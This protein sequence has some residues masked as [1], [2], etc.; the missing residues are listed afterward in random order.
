MYK[1]LVVYLYSYR[2][3]E[4][5]ESCGYVKMNIHDGECKM[6]IHIKNTIGIKGSMDIYLLKKED[7]KLIGKKIMDGEE[8]KGNMDVRYTCKCSDMGGNLSIDEVLGILIYNGKNIQK[9]ICG[10]MKSE[11]I[12]IADYD[13]PDAMSVLQTEEIREVEDENSVYEYDEECLKQKEQKKGSHENMNGCGKYMQ[14]QE[15]KNMEDWQEKIFHVFPKVVINVNGEETSGIKLKPHD[16]VWFPGKYWRLASNKFLLNGYY[17][18]RY[19]LFFKGTGENKG[20]YYLGTPGNFGVNS[21]ITA[22]QFGF[23]DFFPADDCNENENTFLEKN[24]RNFGFW[25][26]EA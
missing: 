10:A 13:C 6:E 11:E 8:T 3:L 19:I 1:R 9:C 20:R 5:K 21:A 24:T 25:C 4:K 7:G 15:V 16:I 12:N 2:E 17:N 14:K 23:T 26:R 18:Y 22:R